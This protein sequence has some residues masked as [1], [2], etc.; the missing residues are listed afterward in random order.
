VKSLQFYYS[1]SLERYDFDDMMTTLSSDSNNEKNKSDRIQQ[2]INC[3]TGFKERVLS[4]L[5]SLIKKISEFSENIV[6]QLNY[7]IKVLED[8]KSSSINWTAI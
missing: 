1:N 3:L 6:N 4:E 5:S 8:S 2:K 7:S